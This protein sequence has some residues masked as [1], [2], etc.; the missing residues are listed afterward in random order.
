MRCTSRES[1]HHRLILFGVYLLGMQ[2]SRRLDLM[3]MFHDKDAA[4]KLIKPTL[5]VTV[6]LVVGDLCR[7]SLHLFLS[8]N[9]AA[10]AAAAVVAVAAAAR[11]CLLCFAN[12]FVVYLARDVERDH[13][14]KGGQGQTVAPLFLC[15]CI[16][17]RFCVCAVV[18]KVYIFSCLARVGDRFMCGSLLLLSALDVYVLYWTRGESESRV[19]RIVTVC[20]LYFWWWNGV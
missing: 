8:M 12:D 10:A 1:F 5:F 13:G 14:E 20:A 9:L 4:N 11:C 16:M 15:T 17:Y 19:D 18:L 2:C 3:V 7:R 6:V